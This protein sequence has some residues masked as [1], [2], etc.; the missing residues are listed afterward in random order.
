MDRRGYNLNGDFQ[1]RFCLVV[2]IFSYWREHNTDDFRASSLQSQSLCVY[3][4]QRRFSLSA[5]RRLQSYY[6]T[7]IYLCILFHWI[8]LL[9]VLVH[10]VFNFN[11]PK[12]I[13][14][15]LQGL[16]QSLSVSSRK[17]SCQLSSLR[18]IS[19]FSSFCCLFTLLNRRISSL[20][21]TLKADIDK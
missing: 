17:V 12:V 18:L 19:G 10:A 4:V 2:F 1:F 6:C 9:I 16:L 13:R 20:H 7:F 21:I 14:E 11:F 3:V 5:L 15:H 8:N